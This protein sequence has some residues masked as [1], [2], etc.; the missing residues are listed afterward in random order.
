M[1]KKSKYVSLLKESVNNVPAYVPGKT[2][3]QIASECGLDKKTII[4]L[5][6][7][8][9]P[10][11]PSKKV[12]K[13]IQ[14]A[15]ESASC[16]P[17]A[18]AFDLRNA[19]AKYTVFPIENIVVSGSGM[20][21]IIDSL[22]KLFVESS[23][24]VILPVP[25]FTYYGISAAALGGT[26]VYVNRNADFSISADDILSKVTDRT[27]IIYLCSPNNPTGNVLDIADVQKLAENSNAIIFIDEAYIEF[28]ESGSLVSMI[29]DYENI[30]VGRTF[31][32]AFG[33]AGMRIGYAVAPKWI[34]E[35]FLRITP[36]FSVSIISEI[37]AI[38]ALNDSKHLQKSIQTVQTERQKLVKD[39]LETTPYKTQPTE[40]NFILV[41][42]SPNT[43]KK[44]VATFLK[45]GIVVRSCD[46]FQNLG[47]ST[48]RITVGTK[49]MNR[50]VLKA[51]EALKN[52]DVSQS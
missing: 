30:V 26:P 41:D 45:Y 3:D 16:Y 5:N 6:S 17:S 42:V 40:S 31:S 52:E 20:D 12:I 11:G 35:Q 34:A 28:S 25:T 15:A 51:F 48:I 1:A 47:Q 23:D 21:S 13:A 50:Y 29:R 33:L 10:L 7:N 2:T 43:S 8:E 18:D 39:I 37:A 9:N 46:S 44:A 4:K 14:E 38:A 24:E 32:K 49:K 22:N 27:K 19:L 36:P